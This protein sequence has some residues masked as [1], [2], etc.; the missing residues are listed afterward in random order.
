MKNQYNN[1]MTEE[2]DL[3]YL[4]RKIGSF[5]RKIVKLLFLI[6]AFFKKYI[7]ITITL[8]V[9]G[10]VIGYFLDK[11]SE[12]ES[13]YE[14][15]V[16]VIPNFES[17]DYLYETVEELNSKVIFRDTVYLKSILADD[18][19]SLVQVEIE[20]IPD[21]Y[22][23]ITQSRENIDALRILFQNQD[24]SE[25]VEDIP[26]SKNYK[27]HKLNFMIQGKNSKAI[28]DKLF[29]S[30]NKNE[31]FQEYKQAFQ[32][33]T[34]LQL[35]HNE[36][37]LSQA[38]SIIKAATE[39]TPNS[40]SDQSVYISEGRLDMIL[41]R[42]Q[43]ILDARLKLQKKMKDQVEVVKLV[44]A[45]YNILHTSFFS[46][47]NKVKLPVLL[48]FLFSFFFFIRYIYKSLKSIAERD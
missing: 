39:L 26:T 1:S 23:F 33:N 16:I 22:N 31:H 24:F 17:V 11:Y 42:K 27:Y 28:I 18:Y 41:F 12:K 8:V 4:F 7:I 6:I 10:A 9:V 21:I 40:G 38:D 5:F 46:F 3:G 19:E 15:R 45:N 36:L 20:P 14:N 13:V 37:M 32:E 29:A 30:I 47:S 2:V 35:R 44:S 48:L 43:E 25:F 34:K